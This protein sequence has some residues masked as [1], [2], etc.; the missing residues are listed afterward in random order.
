MATQ[1]QGNLNV[2]YRNMAYDNPSYLT[3]V[4]TSLGTISGSGGTSTT[5]FTAF[6]QLTVYGVTFF[7]VTALGS[8]T[9]T[10]N[11]TST[12]S[13]MSAY[14]VFI[15]NTNTSGT[16]VTLAT[17]TVGAAS[18]GPVFVAGT[19][20][21]N[22][23]VNVQ[24]LGGLGGYSK[25]AIN[26]LGG[27]NTTMAWGT[28]TYSSVAGGGGGAQGQGG[29]YMNPGD[30]FYVIAGTDATGTSS[31]ILEYSIGAPTGYVVA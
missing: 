5:K 11:G 29:L 10:V 26:T 1:A 9:Y 27:T 13:A 24:G 31:H 15:A 21:F 14:Y 4:S 8:S 28:T 19:G 7:P 25:Y 16:A 22:S 17:N 18:T 30:Q 23:N 6:T 12:T 20:I 2:V 3:R